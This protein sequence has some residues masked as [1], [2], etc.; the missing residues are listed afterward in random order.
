MSDSNNDFVTVSAKANTIRDYGQKQQVR[1]DLMLSSESKRVNIAGVFTELVKRA[2]STVTPTRI[3]DIHDGPVLSTTVPSGEE[4]ISRFSV[5]KIEQGK[6]LKVVLGFYLQ[7]TMTLNDLKTAVDRKW[8]QQQQIYLRPQR[9]SFEHGTDLYLIGY[10]V[11]EHPF[12]ANLECL[13]SNISNKWFN[14]SNILTNTDMTDDESP[15]ALYEALVIELTQ[16]QTIINGKLLIPISA[17]KNVIKVKAPGKEMFETPII[18]IYVP[19]KYQAAATALNDCSI[20]NQDDL[21]LIPF[22]LSK[23]QPDQ[24]YYHMTKHA[25]FLH[26]HRNIQI[27][28]VSLADYQNFSVPDPLNPLLDH[29]PKTLAQLLNENPLIHRIY[30]HSSLNKI[31]ISVLGV[32]NFPLVGAWL[33]K[34]LPLFPYGPT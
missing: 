2:T 13:E 30:P 7:S 27:V 28:S 17:E 29:S 5:A 9:M 22:S 16:Q 34:I 12:T 20:N 24:F 25:E 15:D 10:L 6:S 23:N 8:L 1:M 4:F 31:Q 26:V 3:F 21:S 33:D 18:S 14:P 32:D 19:R 11:Q